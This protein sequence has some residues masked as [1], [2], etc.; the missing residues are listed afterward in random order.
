LKREGKNSTSQNH[1]KSRNFSELF[2]D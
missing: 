2:H 1:Q